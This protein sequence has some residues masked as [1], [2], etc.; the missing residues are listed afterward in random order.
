MGSWLAPTRKSQSEGPY[1]HDCVQGW[2]MDKTYW[3]CQLAAGER[4]Q[5]Q[6]GLGLGKVTLLRHWPLQRMAAVEHPVPV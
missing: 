5:K 3:N 1:R 4:S 2:D 6:V